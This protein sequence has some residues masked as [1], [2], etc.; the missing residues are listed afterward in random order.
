MNEYNPET[1]KLIA[2]RNRDDDFWNHKTV[3]ELAR[4]QGVKRIT[5]PTVLLGGWPDDLND[6]FDEALAEMRR[7]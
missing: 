4:E 5:D 7:A 1:E 2:S 6:G 3:A